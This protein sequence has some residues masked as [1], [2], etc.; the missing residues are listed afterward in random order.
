MQKLYPILD[1]LMDNFASDDLII[2]V[3]FTTPPNADTPSYVLE[4]SKMLLQTSIALFRPFY[5]RFYLLSLVVT[6]KIN[7]HKFSQHILLSLESSRFYVVSVFPLL[8]LTIQRRRRK[9]A[10][11]ALFSLDNVYLCSLQK[12]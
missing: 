1:Y 5:N 12:Q 6:R 11:R 7:T 8:K 2:D 3:F 4:S 9:M 10:P